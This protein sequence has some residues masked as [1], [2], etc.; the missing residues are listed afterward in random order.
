[1]KLMPLGVRVVTFDM[2]GRRSCMGDDSHTAF[3]A[4][5]ETA[6]GSERPGLSIY[7]RPFVY[8]FKITTFRDIKLD[9]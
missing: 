3:N 6:T 5:D 4:V 8:H 2:S 7:S 1:M 9:P